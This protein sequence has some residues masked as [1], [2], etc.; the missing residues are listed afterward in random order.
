MLFLEQHSGLQVYHS[1]VNE[2]KCVFAWILHH[3]T[4]PAGILQIFAEG[5]LHWCYILVVFSTRCCSAT[6]VFIRKKAHQNSNGIIT[7]GE[8]RVGEW[9]LGKAQREMLSDSEM[10]SSTYK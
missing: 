5:Q 6:H 10:T 8:L 3:L 9:I 1:E 7:E 4:Q 2:N